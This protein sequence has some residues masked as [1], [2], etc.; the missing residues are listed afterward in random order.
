MTRRL[1]LSYLGLALL[2]LVILE[3][4]LAVLA[5][6]HERDLSASQAARE[7]A[8][9]AGLVT[10][11]IEHLRVPELSTLATTYQHSTGGEVA[12]VAPGGAVLASS[13][14]DADND[15]TSDWRH[16]VQT[17]LGGSAASSFSSDEGQ[18][19]AAAVTPITVDNHPGG[20]VLLSVPAAGTMDRVHDIWLA[21][22]ALAAGVLVMT[23]VVGVVLA[24][25]LSRP[26]TRLTA[27]VGALGGGDLK[28]RADA[29]RG[30]PQVKELAREF[31]RMAARL[32]EL[33]DAQSRFVAD[34]SHQLRSP[35]T[36]LRLRLENVEADAGDRASDGIAAAGR[37]LQRLS[38]VV[39]GLL[40]LNRAG[41]DE[42]RRQSVDLNAV[43][44]ERCEAWSALADEKG[45]RLVNSEAD[46]DRDFLARLV[47]GDLEQILDNL[48][49]NALDASPA[50]T[51]ITV[52][53]ESVASGGARIRV[54]D[55]GPGMT[56]EERQRAFDRFWRGASSSGGHSGLGLA[57]VRQLA[58]RN[59]ATVELLPVEPTG[60]DALIT[61]AA[62]IPAPRRRLDHEAVS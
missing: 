1:L 46:S 5:D 20:V 32:S 53:M 36:A 56:A 19:S 29:G 60:L 55:Q 23:A 8:G 9:L 28:A 14:G 25:S 34:A 40:T 4:P 45:V 33:V 26:L 57:I 31:N 62:T 3:V 41:H 37:E 48:L 10:E 16:L 44:A 11:D 15:V 12:I 30:P 52:N 6:R 17:G 38:R 24:R 54:V 18:P 13:S 50:G 49:A 51:T 35:L 61:L 22:A 39:D 21:L 7:A 58:V 43:I 42:T 59:D 2:I 47:P 27:A